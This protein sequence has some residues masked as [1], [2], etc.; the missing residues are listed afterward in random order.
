[1]D[2]FDK[3]I[4]DI[5]WNDKKGYFDDVVS[6]QDKYIFFAFSISLYHFLYCVLKPFFVFGREFEFPFL[7]YC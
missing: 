7:M 4:N 3:Y 5:D 2:K 6:L 1:M